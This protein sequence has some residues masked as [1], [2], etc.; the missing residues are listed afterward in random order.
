MKRSGKRQ[1]RIST[2]RVI[3]YFLGMLFVIA[4]FYLPW[5][6]LAALGGC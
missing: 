1:E 6:A 2:F 4:G 3:G 5:L